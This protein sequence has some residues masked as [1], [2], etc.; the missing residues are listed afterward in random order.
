VDKDLS[1]HANIRNPE[2]VQFRIGKGRDG[3]RGYVPGAF[4]PWITTFDSWRQSYGEYVLPEEKKE[5]RE[6]Y[7][8]RRQ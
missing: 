2:P 8:G 4:L 7:H 1:V 5:E 6:H 3:M